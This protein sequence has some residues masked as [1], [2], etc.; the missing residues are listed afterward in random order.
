MSQ[1]GTTH[2]P[3]HSDILTLQEAAAFLRVSP[4]TVRRMVRRGHV[5]AMRV[6][7]R[8][9]RFTRHGLLEDLHGTAVRPGPS[10]PRVVL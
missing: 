5:R 7:R 3:T 10:R 9:L 6:G 2:L 1:T 8:A 4:D